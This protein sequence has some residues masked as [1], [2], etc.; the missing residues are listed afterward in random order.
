MP[1]QKLLAPVLKKYFENDPVAA[2]RNLESLPADNAVAALKAVPA[3][4]A[5]EIVKRLSDSMAAVMIKDLPKHLFQEIS[6]K[7]DSQQLASI[8]LC[9]PKDR[10]TEL[11]QAMGEKKKQEVQELLTFPEDSAGRLMSSVFLSVYSDI[12]VKDA[13]QKIKQLAQKGFPPSYAYVVD[14]ENHLVGVMT[15]R[16]TL[17]A[18]KN[19]VVQTVMKKEIFAIDSFMDREQVAH[20]LASRRFFAAPVVDRENRMLGVVKAD[21]LLKGVQEEAAEDM[22]RM[23][24]VGA[25]EKTFSTIGFSLKKRLPWLHINLATAFLAAS[26][27]ALFEDIIAKITVLAVYL[28]VV[29]GQGGNAGAQS[30]AVVMRGLV[31]REIPPQKVK[32]LVLKETWIGFINGIVIGVVTALAASLWQGNPYLGIVIGLG[33][34]VNLTVAGLS[35]AAIPLVMKALR[36]DPAQCSNIILTTITDVMGFFAFLGFAVLFQNYL[37]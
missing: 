3:S 21:Q 13:V 10:Q 26:V 29:A 37:M 7:L 14:R 6:G 4:A 12:V 34:I 20:E 18:D 17:L 19:A 5:V 27:V 31:M 23:F 1:Q 32:G 22:Q 11:L 9:L 36:L 33:M 15:M 25:D 2:A 30:L 28:P 24:G 8:F 16:D 35:G